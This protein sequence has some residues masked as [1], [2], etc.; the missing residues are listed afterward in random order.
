MLKTNYPVTLCSV[1]HISK[2]L[3]AMEKALTFDSSELLGLQAPGE[4]WK[5]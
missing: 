1:T 5:L 2:E 3:V 4:P